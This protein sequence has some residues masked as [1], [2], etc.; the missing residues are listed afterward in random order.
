M[1]TPIAVEARYPEFEEPLLE[2]ARKMVGIAGKV[3][4]FVLGKLSEM[5]EDE[6][7][8]TYP[9]TQPEGREKD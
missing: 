7:S 5:P 4:Y 1:L 3:R 8:Q 9:G 2:D 6:N